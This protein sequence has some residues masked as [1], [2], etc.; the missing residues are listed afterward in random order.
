MLSYETIQGCAELTSHYLIAVALV[1]TWRQ[2]VYP[3]LLVNSFHHKK[4]QQNL[5]VI[6]LIFVLGIF[7]VS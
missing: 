4:W 3:I 1:G 2:K 5:Y 6:A 7:M